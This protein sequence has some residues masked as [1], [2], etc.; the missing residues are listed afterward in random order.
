M[1]VGSVVVGTVVVVVG[2][3]VV[4]VVVGVV[5]HSHWGTGAVTGVAW[6][7][8][9]KESTWVMPSPLADSFTGRVGVDVEIDRVS[10]IR[11]R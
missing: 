8:L 3:V 5:I 11:G 7:H 2:T 1:V 9:E 10:R 6:P 4:V